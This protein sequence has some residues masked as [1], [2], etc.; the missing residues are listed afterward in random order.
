MEWEITDQIF[1]G[2]QVI[3]S[4]KVVLP[5]EEEALEIEAADLE[6]H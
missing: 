6:A 4:K 1:K 5:V 3:Q 2:I